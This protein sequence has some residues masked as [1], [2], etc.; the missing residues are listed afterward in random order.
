MNSIDTVCSNNNKIG[1]DG[2]KILSDALRIS[3]ANI[4]GKIFNIFNELI[5]VSSSS[6]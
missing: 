4:K 6:F 3:T 2:A 5:S 1:K